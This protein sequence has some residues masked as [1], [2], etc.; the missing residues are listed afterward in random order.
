[1]TWLA[2]TTQADDPLSAVLGLTPGVRDRYLD[3]EASVWSGDVSPALLELCR[4]RVAHL[5]GDAGAGDE[6]TPKAAAAGLDGAK[7][8]ELAQWPTS[9]RFD[10]TERAALSYAETYVIDAH[11]VTEQQCAEL[12]AVLTEPEVTTLITAVAVFDAMS[13][14]RV[15][16][17]V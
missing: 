16:L 3:L 17:D 1:M 11:A 12:N 2:A 6:R 5:L 10:A 9:P 8:A 4:L 13:R 7:V 14:F 15:A